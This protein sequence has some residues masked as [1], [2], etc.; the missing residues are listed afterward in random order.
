MALFG[1]PEAVERNILAMTSNQTAR[2]GELTVA[3]TKIHEQRPVSLTNAARQI[4]AAATYRPSHEKPAIPVL[5]LNGGQD[6]LVHPKCSQ[7]IAKHWGLKLAVHPT[8]GHDLTLDEPA[9]ALEQL[10]AR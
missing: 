7:A 4:I 9:W 1:K 6:N 2:H 5:L 8:A 10:Q 3:W